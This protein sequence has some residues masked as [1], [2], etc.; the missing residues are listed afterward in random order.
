MAVMVYLG[1]FAPKLNANEGLGSGVAGT[2]LC[3]S[4]A[5][6]SPFFLNRKKLSASCLRSF[7]PTLVFLPTSDNLPSTY[8]DFSTSFYDQLL[9]DFFEKEAIIILVI[10]PK[11][12]GEGKNVRL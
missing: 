6:T 5:N 7:F 9:N 10:T 1:S 11:M 8:H 4:V 2:V 12:A 3:S